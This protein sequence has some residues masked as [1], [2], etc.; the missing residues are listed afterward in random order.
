MIDALRFDFAA[1]IAS[2]RH[3][4]RQAGEV[5]RSAKDSA[6]VVTAGLLHLGYLES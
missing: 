1:D 2:Q 5:L 6:E 4:G 3:A